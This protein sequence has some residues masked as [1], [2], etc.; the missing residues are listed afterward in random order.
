VNAIEPLRSVVA[1]SAARPDLVEKVM[2]RGADAI[3][4]DLEGEATSDLHRAAVA[5]LPDVVQ[6][7]K[8]RETVVLVRLTPGLEATNELRMFTDLAIDAWVLPRAEDPQQ[9]QTLASIVRAARRPSDA[10]LVPLIQ[11]ARG[12]VAAATLGGCDMR[13]MALAFDGD[14]FAE[15]LGIAPEPVGLAMPGQQVVLGARAAGRCV[16]G[17]PGAVR[18]GD[19]SERFRSLCI[20]G[21]ALGFTGV[22][23]SALAQAPVA[24]KV[25]RSSEDEIAW[26]DGIDE[27]LA[28]R[29]S[30]HSPRDRDGR[31][32]D[33]SVVD[34]ARL[35]SLRA[36]S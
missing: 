10:G 5:A 11:T 27:Q 2:G 24:N 21:R 36:R 16:L 29:V 17:L 12:V 1:V 22:L 14:A 35:V 32:I 3:L 25:F 13:V 9:I 6:M 31:L 23:C 7:L 33:R 28:A 19:A 30:G 34:R 18:G 15:D 8:G 26:A 4:L 20:H